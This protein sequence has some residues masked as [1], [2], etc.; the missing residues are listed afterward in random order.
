MFRFLI[1]FSIVLLAPHVSSAYVT[2]GAVLERTT[3]DGT[4]TI[5]LV[6]VRHRPPGAVSPMD[7]KA[8]AQLESQF[9]DMLEQHTRDARV[10]VEAVHKDVRLALLEQNVAIFRAQCAMAAGENCGRPV[11]ELL[12]SADYDILDLMVES[13]ARAKNVFLLDP[14]QRINAAE[15]FITA[16]IEQLPDLIAHPSAHLDETL[17]NT[18]T[19]GQL[20]DRVEHDL[21]VMRRNS[22]ETLSMLRDAQTRA[23]SRAFMQRWRSRYD[24]WQALKS[25]LLSIA[26]EMDALMS[27][28]A[29][30]LRRGDTTLLEL[31]QQIGS[32]KVERLRAM[33]E[34]FLAHLSGRA[35]TEVIVTGQLHVSRLLNILIR[36]GFALRLSLDAKCAQGTKHPCPPEQT[37]PLTIDAFE[38]LF[39]HKTKQKKLEL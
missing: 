30:Q 1:L 36:E 4:Q 17:R 23:E 38:S 28:C 15:E 6:G 3:A 39:G 11:A 35:G 9:V 16:L 8:I 31:L 34:A 7:N 14:R 33:D 24:E 19:V 22:R 21:Q 13:F 20:F 10:L 37:L 25:H 5:I 18:V 12:T 26:Q 29:E 27:V 2:N 32:H